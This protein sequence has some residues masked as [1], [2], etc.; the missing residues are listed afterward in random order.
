M[1]RSPL[2]LSDTLPAG[3]GQLAW[4]APMVSGTFNS[5]I[6]LSMNDGGR[7][8]GRGMNATLLGGFR[9]R[10]RWV[11]L[12]VAPEI[13]ASRN[14][15]FPVLPS[16][17][18]SM[19]PFMNPFH[20]SGYTIDAPLRFGTEPFTTLLP[21]QSSIEA[22]SK[23]VAGG[24][25]SEN[26][27]WGAGI[28]TGIV[29]SNNAAGVPQAY[30]RTATP[31]RTPVGSWEARWLLG[32]L[33]ES[34]YFDRKPSN[35]RRSLSGAVAT[36]RPWFDSNFVLGMSRVSFSR[37]PDGR[38]PGH[39][40]DFILT[41][42][43]N[44][45]DELTALF[46]EWA[47][48]ESRLSLHWEWAR[49]R[50]PSIRE[51]LVAPQRTQGYTLGIKWAAPIVDDRTILRIQ[52]E[53]TML[54]QT[55]PPD[56]SSTLSFYPSR[57]VPQGYTQRGEVIGAAT[58][59]GSSSQWLGADVF[60]GVW[61]A[62]LSGGRIRYEDES[63]YF[64]AVGVTGRSH[65]VSL[66]AGIRGGVE[67]RRLSARLELVRTRRLNYLFQTGSGGYAFDATFDVKNN[68]AN[69]EMSWKP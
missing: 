17:S 34:R 33:T 38:L 16:P 64:Q 50:I 14:R 42:D 45:R 58:G 66:F 47:F 36:V 25:S 60:R 43:S 59:P 51:L 12:T 31:V 32:T 55:L 21:G 41:L 39:F 20:P 9:A 37:M 56:R 44:T 49:L 67:W 26:L 40:G 3:D 69:F 30:L 5:R 6:P 62:G 7:W 11:H 2:A 54:E 27:W 61:S 22:R 48:P 28:R 24:F 10:W 18:D 46:G 68:T 19:S 35:D 63:Y 1:L 65:D 8:S 29:M 15:Q 52:S 4:I 53:A 13:S 23:Y 57:R